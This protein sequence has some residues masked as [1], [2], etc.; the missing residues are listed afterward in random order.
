MLEAYHRHVA[1]RASEIRYPSPSPQ[2]STNGGIMRNTQK[3]ARR[4]QGRIADP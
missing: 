4:T 2:C 3:S 1:E